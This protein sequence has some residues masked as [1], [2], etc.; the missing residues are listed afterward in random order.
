MQAMPRAQIQLTTEVFLDTLGLDS[1]T[2]A[3]TG[4]TFEASRNIVRVYLTGDA[5]QNYIEADV[6]T[7]EG[8]ESPMIDLE[9]LAEQER[10]YTT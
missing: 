2:I 6:Y 9:I 4:V 5:L 10:F 8:L 1:S 3:V 7:R